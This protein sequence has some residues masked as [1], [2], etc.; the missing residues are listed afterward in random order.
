MEKIEELKDIFYECDIEFIEE[1]I[2]PEIIDL[3]INDN[4]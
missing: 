3:F 4:S 1:H 2:T